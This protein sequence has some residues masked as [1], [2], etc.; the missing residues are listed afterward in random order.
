MGEEVFSKQEVST[1]FTLG[2]VFIWPQL[3]PA[4]LTG[5]VRYQSQQVERPSLT[6]GGETDDT[7]EQ[8]RH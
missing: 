2:Y 1:L 3:R 8:Q 4:P 7:L 5:L 6:S